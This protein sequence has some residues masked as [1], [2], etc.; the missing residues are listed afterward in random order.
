M[1]IKILIILITIE[2]LAIVFFLSEKFMRKEDFIFTNAEVPFP[3]GFSFSLSTEEGTHGFISVENDATFASVF[4]ED[5]AGRLISVG[6]SEGNIV[7]YVISDK[8]NDYD[9]RSFFLED[10]LSD[11]A[12]AKIIISREEKLRGI[13]QHYFIDYNKPPYFF[14]SDI[15]IVFDGF[16]IDPV[17]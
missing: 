14:Y 10:S 11:G 15:P 5:I 6:F 8:K 2:T 12:K 1:K 17:E 7:S 16:V 13:K 9:I 3:Y 4:L